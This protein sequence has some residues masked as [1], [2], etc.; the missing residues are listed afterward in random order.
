[1]KLDVSDIRHQIRDTLEDQGSLDS[2]DL[3][4]H[5]A[6]KLGIDTEDV[7]TIINSG[8]TSGVLKRERGKVS[9]SAR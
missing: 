9:L 1:M 8:V 7:K 4:E 3:A 6:N 5:V 2:D